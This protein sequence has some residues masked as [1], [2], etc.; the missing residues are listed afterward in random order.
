M[1]HWSVFSTFSFKKQALCSIFEFDVIKDMSLMWSSKTFLTGVWVFRPPALM[2]GPRSPA[3]KRFSSS[4]TS[5]YLKFTHYDH[6]L[7]V[8]GLFKPCWLTHATCTCFKETALLF[9]VH[10]SYFV[11]FIL[12]PTDACSKF[13]NSF[14]ETVVALSTTKTTSCLLFDTYVLFNK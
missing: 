11:N 5:S 3:P 1:L 8:Y 2:S 14:L 6:V 10:L 12:C 4:S 7:W 9:N 13:T